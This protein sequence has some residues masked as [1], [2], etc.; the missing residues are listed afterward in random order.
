MQYSSRIKL[1]KLDSSV[2][3]LDFGTYVPIFHFHFMRRFHILSREGKNH[4]KIQ[5]D[6]KAKYIWNFAFQ[7]G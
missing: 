6:G 1:S 4:S 5:K 3:G 2:L 7:C